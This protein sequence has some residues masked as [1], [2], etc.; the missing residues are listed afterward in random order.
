MKIHYA[1]LN[2]VGLLRKQNEDSIFFAQENGDGIFLVADG[3]G[4][5]TEGLYASRIVKQRTLVWWETY[6]KLEKKP[7][8]LQSLE[9]LKEAFAE[10]NQ[11]ILENTKK[12]QVCGS[13]LV[14]LW[15]K[16]NHWAVFSCGDSR[17]Y[18]AEEGILFN[19]FRRLTTDDV[20]ENQQSNRIGVR[21]EEL[22]KNKN[23]GKLVRAVGVKSNFSCTVQSN[24]IQGKTVFALCSDGV[25]QYCAE[26]YFKKQLLKCLK[27]DDLKIRLLKIRDKIYE[28]G[29]KDNLSLI[30]VKIVKET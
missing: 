1:A 12:G 16:Q 18:Q 3:M 4:G 28:N 17:C 24:Q 19:K 21:Q 27:S 20:W 29:A 25:Y 15:I 11:M 9:Q 5:H 23:F 8:F 10:S 30:L 2:E 6:L 22:Q 26:I 7:D 14:A 13:T